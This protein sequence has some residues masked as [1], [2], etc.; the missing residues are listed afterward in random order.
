MGIETSVSAMPGLIQFCEPCSPRGSGSSSFADGG[1]R[2]R[3]EVDIGRE[4]A[5][6]SWAL[7]RRASRGLARV[8]DYGPPYCG[9]Q[10]SYLAER[11]AK[12]A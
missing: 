5:D 8:I 12:C 3:F 9:L 2:R 11:G 4:F 7:A 10:E 6:G 1:A